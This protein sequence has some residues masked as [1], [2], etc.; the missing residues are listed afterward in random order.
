MECVC[1][2]I[3]AILHINLADCGSSQTFFIML[4]YNKID[5][6]LQINYENLTDPY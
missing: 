1:K 6:K 4:A 5:R 3:N 2:E